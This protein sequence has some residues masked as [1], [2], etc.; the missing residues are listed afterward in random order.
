MDADHS[1]YVK[2]IE[3][4]ART[5]L[6]LN[7]SAVCSVSTLES[8]LNFV[9]LKPPNFLDPKTVYYLLDFPPRDRLSRDLAVL[10]GCTTHLAP[11]IRKIDMQLSNLHLLVRIIPLTFLSYLG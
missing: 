5:F 4:H 10:Q 11:Q 9:I 1:F 8:S 2:T 6:P 7:I 3:T